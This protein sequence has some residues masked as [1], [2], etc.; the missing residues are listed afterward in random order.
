MKSRILVDSCVIVSASILVSSSDIDEKLSIK[1]HFYEECKELFTF[2]QKNLAKRIGIITYTIENE[3]LG[4]LDKVIEGEL[5]SR[6][7][8]RENF[9][10]FSAVFNICEN[11]MRGLIALLQREPV[12]SAD[13]AQK[14][15]LIK[16]MYEEMKEKA[17][18]LPKT[19]ALKTQTVP[20][21]FR[22]ALNWFEL[23]KTQDEM[24]HAQLYNLLRKDV[25]P[26]DIAILAEA[27]H[28]Y[29]TYIA[30]EGKGGNLYIASKD[31]HFVPVRR[32]G[33]TYEGRE[34]TDEIQK[35]FGIT[36]EHPKKVK[37]LFIKKQ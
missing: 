7:Y 24:E 28:L 11:R 25:E 23:F 18:K 9:E 6:G 4:V 17:V 12:D 27:Y 22:R 15:L 3:A 35:R 16:K 26:S 13:V 20:P 32:K 31:S 37:E 29:T 34:I 2:I 1:H 5:K 14:I 33:W 21:K 36:C 30:T 10:V 8:S 19:A